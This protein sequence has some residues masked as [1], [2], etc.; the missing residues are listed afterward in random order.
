MGKAMLSSEIV[1]SDAFLGLPARAQSL[2]FQLVMEADTD[3][4]VGCPNRV[5]R[6]SKATQKDYETL[7]E[8]RFIIAFSSGVC[9]IKHHWIN[10]NKRKDR[11]KPT[12][13]QKEL[14][15]LRKKE[16][17]AYTE[18]EKQGDYQQICMDSAEMATNGIP[19]YNQRVPKV[20]ESKVKESKKNSCANGFAQFWFAYAKKRNKQDAF[21]A[22]CVIDPDEALTAQI[23]SAIEKA[24]QSKQWQKQDGQFIPYPA[25]WL[26]AGGWEDEIETDRQEVQ[27]GSF[28]FRQT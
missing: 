3:G 6:L 17:G 5:M 16:N 21:R 14:L 26:R 22:W 1:C 24:K 19:T 10:C 2:Y 11:Y 8:H 7:V 27:G 18:I 25:T 9:V 12:T 23:L 20:K 4:F 13:Y 15:Q 28:K